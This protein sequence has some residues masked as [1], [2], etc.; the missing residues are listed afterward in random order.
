MGHSALTR[1]NKATPLVDTTGFSKAEVLAALYNSSKPVGLG[2]LHYNPKPMTADEAY[3]Y[4]LAG[5]DTQSIARLPGMQRLY[6]DYLNGRPIK[7]DLSQDKFDPF[8][9]DRL[10]GKHAARKAIDLLRVK[11]NK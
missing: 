8:V 4:V 1:E 5:D 7:V 2:H 11:L 6:F 3:I 9:Y 10:N